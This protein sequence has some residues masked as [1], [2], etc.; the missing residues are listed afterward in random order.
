M[1]GYFKQGIWI[2][3]IEEDNT[4]LNKVFTNTYSYF[5]EF[6]RNNKSNCGVVWMTSN[7]GFLVVC[8]P[9]PE[10]AEKIRRFVERL[11]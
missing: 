7:T 2:E 11:K 6:N 1:S 3:T 8:T 9:I 10:Y 4:L 5:E